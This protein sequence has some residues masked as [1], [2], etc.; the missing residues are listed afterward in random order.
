MTVRALAGWMLVQ[1][2][3]VKTANDQLRLGRVHAIGE[4]PDAEMAAKIPF[5]VGDRICWIETPASNV[6]VLNETLLLVPLSAPMA[7]EPREDL[8]S[9]QNGAGHDR[10]QAPA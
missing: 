8:I 9:D 6:H 5:G 10:D 7:Y 1:P 2:L 3:N 4:L